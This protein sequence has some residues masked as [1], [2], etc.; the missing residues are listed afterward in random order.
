MPIHGPQTACFYCLGLPTMHW[1]RA[2]HNTPS[3][4]HSNVLRRI[5]NETRALDEHRR[6][7]HDTPYIDLDWCAGGYRDPGHGVGWGEVEMEMEGSSAAPGA[8][9]QLE[10]LTDAQLL[11]KFPADASANERTNSFKQS[12]GPS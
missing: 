10:K 1:V 3:R 5:N 2:K 6:R 11:N 7:C 4:K 9:L 8:H 12:Q